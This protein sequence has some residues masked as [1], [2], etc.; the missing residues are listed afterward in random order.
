[1]YGG[2][3][4]SSSSHN[5]GGC[6]SSNHRIWRCGI[7]HVSFAIHSASHDCYSAGRDS[8]CSSNRHR[9]IPITV[10]RHH[11][12]HTSVLGSAVGVTFGMYMLPRVPDELLQSILGIFLVSYA[13]YGFFGRQTIM[14]SRIH[15]SIMGAVAGFFSAFFNIQGPLVGLYVSEQ[16]GK[17]KNEVKGVI[18]T[19]MFVTGIFTIIG[20]TLAGRMTADVLQLTL[21]LLPFLIIGL[22]IGT[23]VYA[24]T[25]VRQVWLGILVLVLIAGMGLLIR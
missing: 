22:W 15:G 9:C 8:V 25:N 24:K 17:K 7:E 18:S 13:L 20:H 21:F 2:L 1:M 14:L 3:C 11:Q 5:I 23:K 19:Y 10:S 4:V 12:T 6:Y 16:D